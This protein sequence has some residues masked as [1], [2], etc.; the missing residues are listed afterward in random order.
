MAESFTHLG[1]GQGFISS[2]CVQKIDVSGYDYWTTYSGTNKSSSVATEESIYKDLVLAVKLQWLG[3]KMNGNNTWTR[4]VNTDDPDTQTRTAIE[5]GYDTYD[6][7]D[8]YGTPV[9]TN[10]PWPPEDRVCGLP[11]SWDCESSPDPY[12]PD[13]CYS[14]Q[15]TQIYTGADE[16]DVG[17]RLQMSFRPQFIVVAMYDGPASNENNFVGYGGP[18]GKSWDI[19]GGTGYASSYSNSSNFCYCSA[20]WCGYINDLPANQ[21]TNKVQSAGYTT[22]GDFHVVGAAMHV[23]RTDRN[24]NG[25]ITQQ[26]T[27]T[28]NG[29]SGTATAIAKFK[30]RDEGSDPATYSLQTVQTGAASVSSID[31]Y[32]I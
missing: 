9:T 15:E 32:T 11:R 8:P 16:D 26:S 20:L 10:N 1:A 24:N 25:E 31:Y 4:G 18:F 17:R 21:Q 2:R 14:W 12:F 23:Q 13:N 27:G 6:R 19:S 7:S 3:K 5:I 28:A 29:S 22:V 30:L